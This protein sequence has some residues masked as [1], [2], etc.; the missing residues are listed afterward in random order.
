MRREAFVSPA[1]PGTSEKPEAAAAAAGMGM[2]PP[3]GTGIPGTPPGGAMSKPASQAVLS[4]GM[5]L[6]KLDTIPGLSK[7]NLSHCSKGCLSSSADKV[8]PEA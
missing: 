4:N 5:S 7:K 2:A 8:L 6:L 3:T 1:L